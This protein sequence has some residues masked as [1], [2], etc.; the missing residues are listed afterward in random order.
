MFRADWIVRGSRGIG[1]RAR[2]A[3]CGLGLKLLILEQVTIGCTEGVA[4]F[5]TIG[6]TS[7]GGIDEELGGSVGCKFAEEHSHS[8]HHQPLSSRHPPSRAPSNPRVSP[9]ARLEKRCFRC[10]AR[11]HVVAACRDPVRCLRCWHTGHRA[12]FCNTKLAR[13]AVIMN[14]ALH[15][16]GRAP[17]AKVY[18]PFTEEYLRRVELRRNALLADVIPPANL[19]P[20]PINTIKSALARRFGGYNEDFSVA[21]CRER[22]FAVFLPEWVPVGVLTR[23]EI[24]TLDGFWLRCYPWGQYRDARPHPVQYKAW[25]RLISL[26]FEIWTVPRVAALVSGFG[27]FIKADGPTKALTDLRAF[28]CQIALDSVFSIPQNLSVIVGEERFPVIVHL[29]MWE[30]FEQGGDNAPPG[31]PRLDQ[32]EAGGPAGDRNPAR[33]ADGG[34]AGTDEEMGDAPGELEQAEPAPQEPGRRWLR[35]LTRQRCRTTGRRGVRGRNLLLG[36]PR[37]C[38]PQEESELRPRAVVGP[39]WVDVVTDP[40]TGRLWRRGRLSDALPRWGGSARRP[41]AVAGPQRLA[42]A[43]GS[44]PG[45]PGFRGRLSVAL[46]PRFASGGF[47][48][49]KSFR[50]KPYLVNPLFPPLCKGPRLLGPHLSPPRPTK[51]DLSLSGLAVGLTSGSTSLFRAGIFSTSPHQQLRWISWEGRFNGPIFFQP[52]SGGEPASPSN[53]RGGSD[54]LV[55]CSGGKG[56]APLADF[57]ENQFFTPTRRTWWTSATEGVSAGTS[58]YGT[59]ATTAHSCLSSPPPW[60]PRLL[61]RTRFQWSARPLWS[62]FLEARFLPPACRTWWVSTTEEVKAGTIWYAVVG[63]RQQD[64]RDAH[65]ED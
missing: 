65:Y 21:R 26:P 41:S 46:P 17:Q 37:Y 30:R 58:W 14:R 15:H 54:Y 24:L 60:M 29:E 31:P 27:R 23:R 44:K 34:G 57:A 16:R 4:T 6:G 5:G 35:S 22:D 42:V 53:R 63:C 40:R 36:P 55:A 39:R 12:K 28:R 45:R 10:L 59:R 48:V 43:R 62:F 18:V 20:D 8:T 33:Q 38:G 3:Y 32:D 61:W 50:S 19:G 52:C 11:D 47:L 7:T 13:S 64:Y 51:V 25:I 9:S 49:R 2:L 1:E 56:H